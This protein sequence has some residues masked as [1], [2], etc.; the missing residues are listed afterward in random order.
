MASMPAESVFSNK[1]GSLFEA[2]GTSN[3]MIIRKNG[4]VPVSINEAKD[5]MELNDIFQ[6]L[7][8][9]LKKNGQS[10]FNDIMVQIC[11]ITLSENNSQSLADVIAKDD[12]VRI[13][14]DYGKH[15]DDSI[16][17]LISKPRSI[18]EYNVSLKESGKIIGKF[19]IKSFNKYLVEVYRNSAV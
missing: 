13:E 12:K 2:E 3:S 8:R 18:D 16:G 15:I 9:K 19:D 14:V 17:F 4:E 5:V 11:T 7:K 10:I 6:I 1:Y